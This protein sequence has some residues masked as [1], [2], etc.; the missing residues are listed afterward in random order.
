MNSQ[1]RIM[2]DELK[3][4]IVPELRFPE[5]QNDEDWDIKPLKKVFSIFQ[6]YAFSSKDSVEKGTR[7]LKI[8][9][10]SIQKMNHNN[11]SFLPDDYINIY[12]SFLIKKGDYVLALTRPILN[13]KLKISTVD[14]ILHNSLLNQRVGKL[15]SNENLSLVYYLLQTHY[16]I[17]EIEKSIAGSE[18]PNLSMKQ[19]EDIA[20]PLPSNPTE[21]QKIANCLSSLD[22]LI[23]AETEKLDHLKDHKK[24]L[25]QQLFPAKGETKPQFRFPEFE[26]DGDWEEKR[27]SDFDDLISGD[28]DWI[29]SE[30]ITENGEYKI[31][32]LSSTGF[33]VFLEKKLKTISKDTFIKLKGTPILKGD[34]LI[35]RMVDSKKINNCIFPL[36]G[37]YVTSVDVCWI[38]ENAFFNNYFFMNLLCTNNNQI[39]LLSLS[40]GAGRVRIS[41]KNLFERFT[42][43]LPKD[44]KEQQKIA[45]C[46]SSVDDLIEV[47]TTKIKALKKHKKGLM[48]QLF[49]NVNDSA[50]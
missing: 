6:G 36:E 25:L 39:K 20:I 14:E 19:I 21:Q 18:P 26:N 46:L 22:N 37:K 16:L 34:L 38:R 32:Q 43:L 33:G 29:L 31:I 10:V 41:K 2:N 17:N 50:V 3:I 30:N 44:P 15:V 8:A 4:K 42:F 28:G 24:G 45:D 40:S 9:D 7:W 1:L 27:L 23:T 11:P 12:K 47:Q 35:N 49:P 13:G 5:F 48:Q